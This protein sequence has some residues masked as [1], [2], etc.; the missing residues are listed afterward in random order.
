MT[1][2]QRPILWDIYEEHLDEA[3][4]LWGQWERAMVSANY[5]IDEVIAGP[6]ERLLAHLDGL[7]LGGLR[8]AD[9]LLIP[10]LADEDPGKVFAAAWALLQAEDADHLDLV[11]GKLPKTEGAAFAALARALELS[12]RADLAAR[13][14]GLW[15]PSDARA[16]GA[17]LDILGPR[18]P[19]WAAVRVESCLAAREAGVQCSALRALRCTLDQAL[20]GYVGE[21]LGSPNAAVRHE[22]IAT[23]YVM[24]IPAV[25]DV[26]RREA[27]AAGEACRLPLALLALGGSPADRELVSSRLVIPEARRHALWALGFF[28]D[29]E[30]A[31]RLVAMLDDEASA[32]VAGESLS[33]ITGIVIDGPMAKPGKTKG[34]GVEDIQP[35]DPLPEVL[36]EDLLRVPSASAV[37]K[38]WEKARGRFQPGVRYLCGQLLSFDRLRARMTIAMWRRQVVALEAATKSKAPLIGARNWGRIQRV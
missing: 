2:A 11:V 14:G 12:T 3:A 6:E 28:G 29:V 20:G 30:T 18:D 37:R 19:G 33:A 35:D 8:V 25:L 21:G 32:R 38:W 9:K 4:F 7:V 13:L 23:G 34:P 24:R 15:E 36:P 22:A 26:C 1:S 5:T 17:L 27:L 10:A 16:R 31:D